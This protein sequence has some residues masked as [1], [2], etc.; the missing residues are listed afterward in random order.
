MSSNQEFIDEKHNA[1]ED[2]ETY[3]IE[4][5]QDYISLGITEYIR[6]MGNNLTA[7]TLI[8]D[9]VEKMLKIPE[10]QY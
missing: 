9:C 6:D 2:E 4:Q 3:S 7:R 5:L 8:E 10:E 1:E